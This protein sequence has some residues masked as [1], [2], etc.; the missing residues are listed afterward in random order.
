[1][2]KL[3]A[4]VAVSLLVC[5]SPVLAADVSDSMLTIEKFSAERGDAQSQYFMGEHYEYGDSG[6]SKDPRMALSWYRK[7]AAQGH[8][9]AQYKIGEFFAKGVGGLNQD[10][11]QAKQWFEKA[12]ANGSIAARKRLDGIVQAQQEAEQEK[13]R[14]EKRRQA[15]LEREQKAKAEAALAA[16]AANARAAKLAAARKKKKEAAMRKP[17]YQIPE[18]IEGVIAAKWYEGSRGAE[19][20]P[21]IDM[22]CLKSKEEEVTCFSSERLRIINGLELLFSVKSTLSQ[23]KNDGQFNVAYE[24]NVLERRDSAQ[25]GSA[26]DE[27]GLL[28]KQ[29]WQQRLTASCQMDEGPSIECS[30]GKGIKKK[31]QA[32]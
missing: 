26:R 31:Y 17:S 3:T 12:A 22:G 30:Y 19:F 28:T 24:Y 20:L 8:A 15:A 14:E 6:M 11:V 10:P 27:F 32:Q 4:L 13:Q 23:F 29:G 9:A 5:A 18:L 21:T 16:K 2:T 25:R 7:A 1:M